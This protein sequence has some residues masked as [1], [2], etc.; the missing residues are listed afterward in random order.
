MKIYPTTLALAFVAF[1]A[2]GGESELVEGARRAAAH[3]NRAFG[4]CGKAWYAV[5]PGGSI[6]LVPEVR[7][8][9]KTEVLSLEQKLNGFEFKAT[10]SLEPGPFRWWIAKNENWRDWEVG[11]I[12]PPAIVIKRKGVW[13]TETAPNRSE[14]DRRALTACLEIPPVEQEKN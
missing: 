12:A 8:H 13:S 2:L 14:D 10:T 4:R 1:T 9:F 3:W 11:E 5:A 7:M 6:Q